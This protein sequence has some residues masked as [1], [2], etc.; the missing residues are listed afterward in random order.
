MMGQKLSPPDMELYRRIDEVLFYLWD[1]L[2]VSDV[3][4]ARDEYYSYLGPVFSMVKQ[5]K[6]P[7]EVAKH[8]TQVACGPMG[9]SQTPE[10]EKR[11]IEIANLIMSHKRFLDN[12]CRSE[13]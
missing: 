11:D 13:Q 12:K 2:G 8:L 5:D 1:P 4:E 10:S 7:N 6:S 3:P 9:L